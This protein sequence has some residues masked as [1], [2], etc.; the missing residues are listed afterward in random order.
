MYGIEKLVS[1]LSETLGVL[2][3]L[4][5]VPFNEDLPLDVEVLEKLNNIVQQIELIRDD[6]LDQFSKNY[7]WASGGYTSSAQAISTITHGS[8]GSAK[9]SLNRIEFVESN[10]N[11]RTYLNEG[12]ITLDHVD[13]LSRYFQKDYYKEHIRQDTDRLL[14][15]AEVLTA[16]RFSLLM[17]HWKYNIVDTNGTEQDRIDRYESR[18]ITLFQ[19]SNGDWDIEGVLDPVSGELL[20]KALE[21]ITSKIFR[22]IDLDADSTG[23]SSTSVS[24]SKVS[25]N[26]DAIGYLSRGYISSETSAESNDIKSYNF[27]PVF[28]ADVVIDLDDI[29]VS[30]AKDNFFDQWMNN[31]SPISRA[32]DKKYVEQLLCDANVSFPLK[33]EDQVIDLGRSVRVAPRRYKRVLALQSDSCAVDGCSIP[34]RWCDA[35]HIQHWVDGGKTKIENLALLC[36]RHHTMV[37]IDSSFEQKVSEQ[38]F[39]KKVPELINTT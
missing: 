2:G 3:G 19:R 35:H 17:N 16:T 32:H 13:V 33:N 6:F 14:E 7:E 24:F 11:V 5:E 26:V 18:F 10:E 21:D 9:N 38:R 23:G 8:F 37:H 25:A 12:K 36:Q 1:K 29:G 4:S 28:T 22:N 15:C 30:S 34:A 27:A 39:K 20:S 31:V